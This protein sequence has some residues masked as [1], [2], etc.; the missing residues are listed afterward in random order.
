LNTRVLK[1][2]LGF[3]R[4]IELPLAI[5]A[6]ATTA[7]YSQTTTIDVKKC[8]GGVKPQPYSFN[9]GYSFG[10]DAITIPVD[11]CNGSITSGRPPHP[12]SSGTV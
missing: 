6:F 11:L 4:L 12:F 8:D 2:P 1:E 9:W 5:L 3:I 10:L 7:G